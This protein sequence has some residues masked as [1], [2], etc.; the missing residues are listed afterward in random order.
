MEKEWRHEREEIERLKIQIWTLEREMEIS[1]I[2]IKSLKKAN[3]Q[4]EEEIEE[5]SRS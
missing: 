5:I 1:E 3:E 4:R 2:K